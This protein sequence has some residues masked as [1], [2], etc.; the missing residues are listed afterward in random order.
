M[1]TRPTRQP[2]TRSYGA[3]WSQ[4]GR[5]RHVKADL[6]STWMIKRK[7]NLKA[8]GNLCSHWLSV[9]LRQLWII[10]FKVDAPSLCHLI[11]SLYCNCTIGTLTFVKLME[12]TL[13]TK[14]FFWKTGA[15]M[16]MLMSESQR[17]C[18][19]HCLTLRY[20]GYFWSFR[21]NSCSSNTIEIFKHFFGLGHS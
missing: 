1:A 21:H 16:L 11:E 15:F 14:K 6:K 7:P 19:T 10:Y 12:M 9:T 3:P 2:G 5:H 20:T 17:K 4:R 18:K 8:V 13:V